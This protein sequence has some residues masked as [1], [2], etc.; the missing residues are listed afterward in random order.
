MGE[1][2]VREIQKA[3]L[4]DSHANDHEG[5]GCHEKGQRPFQPIFP[6]SPKSSLGMTIGST[7]RRGRWLVRV[8]SLLRFQSADQSLSPV[9][10]MAV[11]LTTPRRFQ[12][13]N[14]FTRT[15]EQAVSRLDI[16]R[17]DFLVTEEIM[18]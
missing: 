1:T 8:F 17:K 14:V 11:H 6:L 15:N 7:L 10:A 2:P 12:I 18:I 3:A 5:I 13:L 4:K 16:K 9:L